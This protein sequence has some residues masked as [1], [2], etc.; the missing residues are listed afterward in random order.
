MHIATHSLIHAITSIYLAFSLPAED[1][2]DGTKKLLTY[3]GE[4]K[5]KDG[6]KYCAKHLGKFEDNELE[7]IADLSLLISRIELWK[8]SVPGLVVSRRSPRNLGWTQ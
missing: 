5:G 7:T 1:D 6:S 4:T 3:I 2:P 8:V